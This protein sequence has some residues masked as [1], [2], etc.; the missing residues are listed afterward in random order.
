[1][2]EE[3]K[4]WGL[5]AEYA[6]AAAFVAAAAR[7]RD[8]GYGK[9]DCYSPFPVHGLD[10]AMGIRRTVL[11][12]LVFGGGL[13]GCAAAIGLQWFVNAPRTTGAA[14]GVFSGYPLVFA[15]KPYWS[16]PANIPIA[17]ELSVL[18]ASLTAFFGLWALVRLPRYYFPAF[19]LRRFRKATD[20]GFFLIIE[21][22]DAKFDPVRTADLLLSTGSVAVEKVED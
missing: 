19:A 16:L 5:L 9:W 21:A 18:L 3:P 2:K 20:D 15:G 11:P 22:E 17:F 1:M 8:A 10:R 12:W 7:V 4:L 6:D 14:A 13:V